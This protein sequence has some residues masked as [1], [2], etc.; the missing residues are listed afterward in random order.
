[1]ARAVIGFIVYLAGMPAALFLAAGSPRWPLAWIYT[2]LFVGATV[3]SRLV[4]W[5]RD[6]GLLRERARFAEAEDV[7]PGDRLLV[8]IVALFAPL[9]QAVVA[10]LDRRYG[11]PPPLPPEAQILAAVVLALGYGLAV[12]AMLANRFFSAVARIQA[13]RGH[14]VVTGGPYRLVR[15]PGYAGGLIAGLAFPVMLDAAWAF[16]P[17]LIGLAALV[18]R[19]RREDRM[20]L[21][22]LPG[23]AAYAARTRFRLVPGV[24]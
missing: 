13:D 23:Y 16:L 12:W 20:L 10:G 21:V 22:G 18:E 1:M 17:A 11:W 24:W 14:V 19:T 3:G 5:R 6:P 7:A 15:H 4:A 8:A 9:A 2:V